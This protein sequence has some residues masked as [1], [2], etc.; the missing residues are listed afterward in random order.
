MSSVEK[1][2]NH[3]KAMARGQIPLEEIYVLN[4]RGRGL[5]NSRKGKIVYRVGQRGSG[6]SMQMVTPVAQGLAQ[7]KSRIHSQGRSKGRK[8]NI[9]R[10]TSRSKHRNIVRRRAVKSKN[11]RSLRRKAIKNNRR[12]FGSAKKRVVRRK[13][14]IF[15]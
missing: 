13:T 2:K 14:D 3:F 10:I 9:K 15:Q 11:S 12:K 5:G 1:W 7:A 4:Q 6:A 8:R